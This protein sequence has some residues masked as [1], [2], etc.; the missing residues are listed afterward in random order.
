MLVGKSPKDS[1]DDQ[2]YGYRIP[3]FSHYCDQESMQLHSFKPQTF[4]IVSDEE[5]K[6]KLGVM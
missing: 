3:L 4:R 2:N 6:W 5:K 1:K